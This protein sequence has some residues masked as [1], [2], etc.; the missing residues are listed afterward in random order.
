MLI[1]AVKNHWFGPI[2]VDPSSVVFETQS[3]CFRN[4]ENVRKQLKDYDQVWIECQEKQVN[5]GK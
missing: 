3:R 5:K 1:V 2:N 4:T